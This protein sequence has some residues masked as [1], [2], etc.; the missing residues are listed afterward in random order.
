MSDREEKLRAC[1]CPGTATPE[2]RALF[3]DAVSRA[4]LGAFSKVQR[5]NLLS[6]CKLSTKYAKLTARKNLRADGVRQ[7][8][9]IAHALRSLSLTLGLKEL[10]RKATKGEENAVQVTADD[11]LER[12]NSDPDN[13]RFGLL[14]PRVVDVTDGR[15]V[16][17]TDPE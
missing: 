12:I 16:P 2:V 10:E 9:R 15:A 14:G 6:Y 3:E 13:P 4:P 1:P 11:M 8:N 7:V 17:E 5:E